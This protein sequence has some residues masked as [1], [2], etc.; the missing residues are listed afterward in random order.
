MPHM[1][2]II[3]LRDSLEHRENYNASWPRFNVKTY[4]ITEPSSEAN[5]E[6]SNFTNS[7]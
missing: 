3:L 6:H 4:L 2:A 1:G 5:A 7:N